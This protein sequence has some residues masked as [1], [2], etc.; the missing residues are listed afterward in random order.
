MCAALVVI[1]LAALRNNATPDAPVKVMAGTRVD[2]SSRLS[3][4]RASRN[5]ERSMLLPATTTSSTVAPP[6]AP[7]VAK[8]K[9]KVVAKAPATT[10]KPKPKAQSTPAPTAKPPAPKP[11]PSSP[12]ATASTRPMP[13]GGQTSNG[14]QEGKAS[15]Y[16]AKYHTNNPWICA[17]KTLPMGTIVTVTS[18]SSGKSIKC[19]VG[20][21]GPYVEGRILDLSKHA[22]SQLANPSSGLVSVKLT[23]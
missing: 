22:F 6:P 18:V 8:P 15:W 19:E 17:H 4:A 21:R 1:S 20:D 7:V 13:T 14:S 23:W 2:F 12:P 5:A 11:A 9:P 3:A 16:D 10:A